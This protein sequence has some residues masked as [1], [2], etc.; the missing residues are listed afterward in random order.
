MTITEI[1]DVLREADLD[2]VDASNRNRLDVGHESS[3]LSWGAFICT[4]KIRREQ[5][6]HW[7]LRLYYAEPCGPRDPQ[8]L[9]ANLVNRTSGENRRVKVPVFLEGN[10]ASESFA[11]FII[12]TLQSVVPK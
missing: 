3:R 1:L 4:N 7:E 6:A 9:Y 5:P 11:K 8:V 2:V 10:I 12:S